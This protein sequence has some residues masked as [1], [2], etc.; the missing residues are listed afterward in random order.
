[1]LLLGEAAPAA[2]KEISKGTAYH[3]QS[4]APQPQRVMH[5]CCLC[6]THQCQEL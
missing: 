6:T 4:P 1:M 5:I 2:Y 3:M